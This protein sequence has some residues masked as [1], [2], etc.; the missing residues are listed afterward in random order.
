MLPA[1][2]RLRVRPRCRPG[3]SVDPG[4]RGHRR[5]R[6]LPAVAAFCRT[7]YGGLLTA[8]GRWGEADVALSD[9][10][11]IWGLGHSW[12]R[13]GALVRLADLRVRQG[14]FEEAEQLLHSLDGDADAR[15]AA[16]TIVERGEP[17]L[18][19]GVLALGEIDSTSVAAARL[20]AGARG[21]PHRCRRPRR[22]RGPRSTASSIARIDTPVSTFGRT[23]A[24]AHGRLCLAETNGDP[25]SYLREALSGF[26][27]ARAPMELAQ[28]HFELAR[29]LAI[30]QPELA[31][32]EA[33]HGLGGFQR[34]PAARQA[35]AHRRAMRSARF[36]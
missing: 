16:R 34:L 8:A 7:H 26:T 31:L 33:R 29:A 13:P 4:R 24:M 25:C 9:A 32:A 22:C 20:S 21:S 14:R 23:A 18:A 30:E 1:V 28:A 12:L 36:A 15:V 27:R 6:N 19:V 5:R 11:R 2:R 17:Q 10:V 35:D 3:R